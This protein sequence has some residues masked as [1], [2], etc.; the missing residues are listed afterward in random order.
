MN[1]RNYQKEMDILIEKLGANAPTLLLHA[2]CA[3]CSS[4]VLSYL[5]EYFNIILCYYNPNI[6]PEEEF[7]KREEELK[8]FVSECNFKHEVRIEKVKYDP[9]RYFELVK[10][11][12]NE[13]EGGKRC[14]VCFRM[15]LLEA[16]KFADEF[17]ADYFATTL[18]I[19]PL[20][21]AELINNIGEEIE[22]E[23]N[24]KAKYLAS[25]FK[26]KEGY[27]KSIEYSKEHNLYRQDYCGC[28]FSQR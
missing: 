12:E 14:E 16:A 11:L 28:I 27:K 6:F 22:K 10:G 25:D 3:P 24:C 1:K 17:N 2:C 15:R 13:K 20:K 9:D 19:S 7:Y 8:R 23:T 4:Y 26:K 21:N 18:T 5:S